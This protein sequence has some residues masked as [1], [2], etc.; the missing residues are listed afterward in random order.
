MR[1]KLLF[2]FLGLT[3]ALFAFAGAPQ[4]QAGPA[5]QGGSIPASLPPA[6]GPRTGPAAEPVAPRGPG[7]TIQR[8]MAP[9]ALKYAREHP[10]WGDTL[11]AILMKLAWFGDLVLATVG[12]WGLL[13]MVTGTSLAAFHLT[14]ARAGGS[15]RKPDVPARPAS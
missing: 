12:V 13:G 14:W 15:R 2:A 4:P 10:L 3:L 1:P 9:A 5:L 8:R 7:T 11:V 6:P